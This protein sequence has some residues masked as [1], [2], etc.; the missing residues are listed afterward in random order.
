[1]E[2]KFLETGRL[3]SV[4][5]LGAGVLAVGAPSANASVV[6]FSANVTVGSG[7]SAS[8]LMDLPG[9][10]NLKLYRSTSSNFSVGVRQTAG[11][12]KVATVG[13]AF[14]QAFAAGKNWN[15]I[16]ATST[17][18]R[19]AVVTSNGSDIS[20]FTAT[21]KYFLFRFADSTHSNA[22]RYGWGEF[23]IAYPSNHA[24]ET[25]VQWAYDDTGA[26]ILSGD[27]GVVTA[28][29]EP[30]SLALVGIGAMVLGAR[31]L[32]RWRAARETKA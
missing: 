8:Y 24:Q 12:V 28:T 9:V 20:E 22:L 16:A 5:A 11:S 13:G 1:M 27:V 6:V 31:G 19:A 18:A 10:A 26:K 2:H 3:V 30:S 32:R 15:D 14:L 29:P 25:L 21:N 7:A 23:T 4:T 17:F